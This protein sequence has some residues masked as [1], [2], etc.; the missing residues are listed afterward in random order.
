MRAKLRPKLIEA[1]EVAEDGPFEVRRCD[2]CAR[3]H[4]STAARSVEP[5]QFGTRMKHDDF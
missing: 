2:R 3:Q 1:V 5:A 4:L